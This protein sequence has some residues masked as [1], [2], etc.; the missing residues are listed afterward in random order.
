MTAIST[1]VNLSFGCQ[2]EV[3]VPASLDHVAT[4]QSLLFFFPFIVFHDYCHFGACIMGVNIS[5]F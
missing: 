4:L 5:F 3:R 2:L 1:I